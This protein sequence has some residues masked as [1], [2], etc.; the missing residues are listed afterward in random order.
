MKRQ[1]ELFEVIMKTILGRVNSKLLGLA[2]DCKIPTVTCAESKQDLTRVEVKAM[3]GQCM[4][5]F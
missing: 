2:C 4:Q 5:V 1:N 3:L